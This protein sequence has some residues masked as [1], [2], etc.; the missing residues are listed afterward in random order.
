MSSLNEYNQELTGIMFDDP[1]WIRALVEKALG[2]AG[3]EPEISYVGRL[4]YREDE[5]GVRTRMPEYDLPVEEAG[6]TTIAPAER[7]AGPGGDLRNLRGDDGLV[8]VFEY[9]PESGQ[10]DIDHG[11]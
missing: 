10:F 2:G 1:P 8:H 6:S 9:N 3:G 11:I 4:A 7:S 5:R